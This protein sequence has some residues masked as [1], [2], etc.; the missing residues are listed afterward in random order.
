MEILIKPEFQEAIK[1]QVIEANHTAFLTYHREELNDILLMK[2]IDKDGADYRLS[3]LKEKYSY[4]N[5][6]FTIHKIE[7]EYDD[8]KFNFNFTVAGKSLLVFGE[9]EIDAYATIFEDATIQQL[10]AWVNEEREKHNEEREMLSVKPF[11]E[12]KKWKLW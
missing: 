1:R 4:E 12:V 11:M 2:N 9:N 6:Y 7:S 3:K 10:K 8:V 5:P